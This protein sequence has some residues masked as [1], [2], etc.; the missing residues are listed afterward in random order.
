MTTMNRPSRFTVSTSDRISRS[1]LRRM[2]DR[3][4]AV[5]ASE[6]VSRGIVTLADAIAI[7]VA[8]KAK[9]SLAS[10][11]DAVRVPGDAGRCQKLSEARQAQVELRAKNR[12]VGRQS[13]LSIA[14]RIGDAYG[15]ETKPKAEPKPA[16]SA[17][18]KAPQYGE[19]QYAADGAALMRLLRSL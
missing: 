9:G 1:E 4:G 3:F 19:G 2:R 15:R 18:S 10:I 16:P 5:K 7:D 12:S 17:K 14:S 11:Q 6:F 13:G 8:P